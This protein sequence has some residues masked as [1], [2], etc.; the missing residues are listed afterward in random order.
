MGKADGVKP[1]FGH[2][3]RHQRTC[4][5]RAS[6]ADAHLQRH[7]SAA[8][9]MDARVSGFRQRGIGQGEDGERFCEHAGGLRRIRDRLNLADAQRLD[10]ARIADRKEGRQG[11]LTT[12]LPCLCDDFRTDPSRITHRY[13]DGSR[14]AMFP[15]SLDQRYSTT[16]SRRK[17]R[18]IRCARRLTRSCSSPRWIRSAEGAAVDAGSSRPHNTSVRTPLSTE[19]KG[20]V[21]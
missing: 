14:H 12:G 17:S 18:S 11:R 7:K 1:R 16:A 9:T 13:G 4:S 15:F 6:E 10:R 21:A 8:R 5:P 3:T 19:P 2:R 20:G